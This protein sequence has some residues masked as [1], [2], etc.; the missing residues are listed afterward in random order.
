MSDIFMNTRKFWII[1]R[2]GAAR[3]HPG[4]AHGPR[5]VLPVLWGPVLLFLLVACTPAVSTPVMTLT[6]PVVVRLE[7]ITPVPTAEISTP[8]PSVTPSLTLTLTPGVTPTSTFTPTA[9]ETNTPAPPTFTLPPPATLLPTITPTL[10]VIDHYHLRRPIERSPDLVDWADRTYPYGGTQYGSRQV[11]TGVD[12][13]NP[14]FTPVRAAADGRVIF[15]GPDAVTRIGPAND[16][17]GNVIIIQHDFMPPEGLPVFTLYGHLQEIDVTA[18]QRVQEGQ[19]I[20]LVGDSGIA[21]GPHLHFEVRV[22]D[23]YDFY[24]TRNPELWL[25]PYPGFG[26][27]AGRVVTAEGRPVFEQTVLVRSGNRTREAYTYAAERVNSDP[28]WSENFTLGDLPAGSYD[29]II[30]DDGAIRFK[31]TVNIRD[32]QTTFVNVVLP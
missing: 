24:S 19:T 13:F 21:I 17:Y 5:A 8:T 4:K 22:G 32:G 7:T 3:Q 16:Y 27:L 12:F 28:V 14:R 25:R 26:T 15:A 9:T 30:S 18:G 23:G 1:R 11:H 6:S 31:E 20:G 10:P 29:V 2:V